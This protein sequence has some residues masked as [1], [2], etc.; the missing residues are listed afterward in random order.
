MLEVVRGFAEG[1]LLEYGLLNQTFT[2]QVAFFAQFLEHNQRNVPT[3]RLELDNILN[4]IA[5]CK[6]VAWREK[7]IALARSA[8]YF[9][10]VAGYT[11]LAK[12]VHEDAVEHARVLQDKAATARALLDLSA[13]LLHMGRFA[14]ATEHCK[15][16][17]LLG[18]TINDLKLQ[19]D[20]HDYLG[21][22]YQLQEDLEASSSHFQEAIS[23]ARISNNYALLSNSLN[24]LGANY[25]TLGNYKRAVRHFEEALLH[26]K[27]TEEERIEANILGNLGSTYGLRLNDPQRGLAYYE[28]AL[29]IRRATNDQRGISAH[30]VNTAAIY[31]NL[32]QL[33]E[34][35][36]RL[37]EAIKIC[38]RI[39]H[40]TNE[41]GAILN[42]AHVKQ[43]QLRTDEAKMY[44]YQTLSINER[45]NNPRLEANAI[46]VLGKVYNHEDDKYA[47]LVL[48]GAALIGL[49]DMGNADAAEVLGKITRIWRQDMETLKEV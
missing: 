49:S 43:E 38:Q 6:T 13:P 5:H 10:H 28:A 44:V 23:I 15:E 14:E 34:A 39:N 12:A 1:K 21:V 46:Y 35:E 19:G 47:A 11:T 4:V 33:E 25:R 2:K 48:W 29:Q 7:H 20:S 24:N 32:G 40:V 45:L 3:L 16:A 37:K 31:R 42:L 30:L 17:L 8:A 36:N 18:L 22:L 27:K 41:A 26:V 9:L